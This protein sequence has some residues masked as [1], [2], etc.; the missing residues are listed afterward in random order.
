MTQA[1]QIDAEAVVIGSGPGG[2]VAAIRLGQLGKKVVVIERDRIGGVCLNIGC[3]PSK[4]LIT[5]GK[6][7]KNVRDGAK[8]GIMADVSV[9]IAKLQAWK[10]GV[11]NRLTSGVEFLLKQNHSQII[12]GSAAFRSE[13]QLVVERR[14]ESPVELMFKSAIIATG[15]VP[16]EL[17]YIKF[18]GKRIISSTEALELTRPPKS[19]LLIGGGVI[20]LEIG[21]AFANLFGTKLTVVELLDQLLPGTDLDLVDPVKKN[22]E[23]LGAKVYL[24]SKVKG[25]SP[26]ETSVKVNFETPDGAA[27][28]AEAEYVLVGVGRKPNTKDLGLEKAGVST[29]EQG[30]VRVDRQMRTNV[31]NL[32]AIGDVTGG[33]LLA[34]KAMK[35]GIVAAEVICGE[36]SEADFHAMPAAIF[37]DPEIAIV[38]LSQREAES[39]GSELLIGKFPF[40]ASG[41]ALAAAEPEG[42][43]KVIAD[44]DSGLVIGVEIVGLDAS[45]LISEASLALEM[46]ATLD[47]I[48]LTIHPHPTMPE[49]IMEASENALGKAIHITNR[50]PHRAQVTTAPSSNASNQS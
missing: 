5:A 23:K 19:M 32:F 30:F 11:V 47:D 2:Y 34:H 35:E 6:L 28:S 9:D 42:F 20:G 40:S 29:T 8:M 37:T 39:R 46:G 49:A 36:N 27:Q 50:R 4:A 16:I 12:R 18:D 10:L 13:S 21:M 44:K 43:A 33:V 14:D 22:L 25:A 17:P 26:G 31:P 1:S 3:I 24:K 45:D 7:V 38:G 48:A 15:T 41:R